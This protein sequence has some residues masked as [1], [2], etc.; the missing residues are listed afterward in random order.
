[1]FDFLIIQTFLNRL[2]S[3]KDYLIFMINQ[4]L[5]AKLSNYNKNFVMIQK[6][7]YKLYT[8]LDNLVIKIK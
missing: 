4:I 1:M 8:L 3:A 6:F 5:D 7:M 2:I